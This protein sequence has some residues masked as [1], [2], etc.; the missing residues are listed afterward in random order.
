MEGKWSHV[1]RRPVI[2]PGGHRGTA[3]FSTGGMVSLQ[4]GLLGDGAF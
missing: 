3:P 2:A 4:K 1:L